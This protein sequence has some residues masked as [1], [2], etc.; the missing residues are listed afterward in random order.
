MQNWRYG[1]RRPGRT[2]FNTPLEMLL[3]QFEEWRAKIDEFLSILHWRC[4]AAGLTALTAAFV[5]ATFNTPLEMP[6][7]ETQ[8]DAKCRR[9][10]FNTPLEML[11]V[12][13]EPLPTLPLDCFQYSIGDARH[14]PAH[15]AAGLLWLSILHWRCTAGTQ[16]VRLDLL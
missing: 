8:R 13:A 9:Y 5:L 1:G 12:P 11:H 4:L 10:T 16:N 2:P 14:M 7:R 3:R 15:T 6:Q